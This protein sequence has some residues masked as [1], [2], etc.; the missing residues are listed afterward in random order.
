VGGDWKSMV[1]LGKG[2][3]L[4]AAPISFPPEPDQGLPWITVQPQRIAP[5]APA[6]VLLMREAH[7]GGSAMASIAYAFFAVAVLTW[8][9]AIGLGARWIRPAHLATA[10]PGAVHLSA[11]SAAVAHR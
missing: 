5:L 1:Y 11:R 8:M 3:V 9:L 2:S 7:G 6:Q 10:M 4:A